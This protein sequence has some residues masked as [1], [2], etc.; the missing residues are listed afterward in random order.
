MNLTQLAKISKLSRSERARLAEFHNNL[1]V[2]GRQPK[3]DFTRVKGWH[4]AN[5]QQ[6]ELFQEVGRHD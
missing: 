2:Y 4:K 1:V 5:W 3:R 6:V